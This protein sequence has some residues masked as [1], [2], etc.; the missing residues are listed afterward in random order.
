MVLNGSAG[1]AD[2]EEAGLTALMRAFDICADI[3][4]AGGETGEWSPT[5]L[6]AAIN[7]A[8]SWGD[9]DPSHASASDIA[10]V[11]E[12]VGAAVEMVGYFDDDAINIP[13]ASALL[14]KCSVTLDG[15]R[16]AYGVAAED[17]D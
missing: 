15:L 16:L 17:R 11:L 12:C 2:C 3:D 8:A 5:V 13:A 14:R 7:L 10:N 6:V 4:G 9:G 1:V